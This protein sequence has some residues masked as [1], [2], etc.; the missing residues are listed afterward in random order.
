M[1]DRPFARVSLYIGDNSHA[2]CFTYQDS[3][4]ILD[5]RAGNASVAVSLSGKGIDE[6]A[7][8]L[9]RELA[10]QA[11]LFATEVE[12]LHAAQPAA[13]SSGDDGTTKATDPKAA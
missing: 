11:Q 7:V 2:E 3:A 13:D 8:N 5:I 9:A 1:S 10:Q 6:A 12:R 4:P